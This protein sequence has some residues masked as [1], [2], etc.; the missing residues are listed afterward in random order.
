MAGLPE[1]IDELT[2]G[3][4]LAEHEDHWLQTS[5]FT[6]LENCIQ[7]KAGAIV[8]L[9]GFEEY[10]D[11]DFVNDTGEVL[12]ADDV[13]DFGGLPKLVR[14]A[15]H[16]A[17][18][19]NGYVFAKAAVDAE[20]WSFRGRCSPWV[21]ERTPLI[22]CSRDPLI[23][24][25]TV[26]HDA[27][28]SG[29]WI[30]TA[31]LYWAPGASIT[32]RQLAVSFTHEVTGV[33][34]FQ[35]VQPFAV[36]LEGPLR[37][38][39]WDN[40]GAALVV[41]G[42]KITDELNYVRVDPSGFG[43]E[44]TLIT[45]A[46]YF[47]R[48]NEDDPPDYTNVSYHMVFDVWSDG[49][50]VGWVA[51]R[52]DPD[53]GD[54]DMRRFTMSGTTL[55]QTHAQVVATTGAPNA[56]AIW[57]SASRVTV[58]YAQLVLG[59]YKLVT[60][61]VRAFARALTL[62][63]SVYADTLLFE[64]QSMGLA[65]GGANTSPQYSECVIGVTQAQTS[66]GTDGDFVVW[67]DPN[68]PNGFDGGVQNGFF[69]GES[70]TLYG[71]VTR[72]RWISTTPSLDASMVHLGNQKIVGKPFFDGTRVAWLSQYA[73]GQCPDA[74]SVLVNHHY[75]VV[76]VEPRCG[77]AGVAYRARPLAQ[78]ALES[79]IACP[80]ASSASANDPLLSTIS[81]AFQD[82]RGAWH[83]TGVEADPGTLRLRIVDYRLVAD[84]RVGCF[85]ELGGATY[86]AGA[87]LSQWDGVRCIEAGWMTEPLIEEITFIAGALSAGTRYYALT[88]A[89]TNA[90][91]ELLRSRP[92]VIKS[93]FNAGGNAHRLRCA[94]FSLTN[95]MRG[96]SLT[97]FLEVWR[98]TVAGPSPM[99]LIKRIEVNLNSYA[100]IEVD[101]L[102]SDSAAPFLFR[103][104]L[105][106][107]GA[108]GQEI[109][110]DPPISPQSIAFWKNRIVITD[111]EQV[112]YSKEGLPS[113]QAEFSLLQTIPR[114]SQQRLTAIA[115]LGDMLA[116]FTADSA[117]YIYGEGP[118]ANGEGSSLTG[119]VMLQDPLGCLWPSGIVV[120]P[121]GGLIVPTRGGLQAL[122]KKLEWSYIGAAIERTWET[123]P[124]VRDAEV[125]LGKDR[126]WIALA[127]EVGSDGSF[128]VLDTL[129]NTWSTM[130]PG[131]DPVSVRA[132]GDELFW[133][134][135]T[136]R[137]Y[138]G[139][140]GY[141][142]A[143]SNLYA[144]LVEAPW[145][146]PGGA[147]AEIRLKRLW[148]L[149]ERFAGGGA[150][151]SVT[152]DQEASGGTGSPATPFTF[153]HTFG[154]GT[155][156]IVLVGV[157]VDL[158]TGAVSSVGVT[159]GGVAM[160]A[161]DSDALAATG[162]YV[163][164]I[165]DANVAAGVNTVEVTVNG[166]LTGN[167]HAA[168]VSFFGVKQVIPAVTAS[169]NGSS[170]AATVNLL[171]T[172]DN[173][174]VV[175]FVSGTGGSTTGTVGAGQTERV[176]SNVGG[177]STIY[178]STEPTTSPASTTMSWAFSA[179][180]VWHTVAVEL[181]PHPGSPSSQLRI[182]VGYDFEE[183]Y[184]HALTLTS[185][186]LDL[187]E[188]E[189]LMARIAAP[190]QRCH[191][192]RVKLTET[193]AGSAESQGFRFV[194]LRMLTALRGAKGP[195]KGEPNAGG[196]FTAQ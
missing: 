73:F 188:G 35:H 134:G 23:P 121:G 101:D 85:A 182:D 166:A 128:V 194:A 27:C 146:K 174:W 10:A 117:G 44:G 37:I 11:T 63:S 164:A 70:A 13:A 123:Y 173:S 4:G 114:A 109:A 122:S 144:M 160:T 76:G 133:A 58:A 103:Q 91:G 92:S 119:P 97:V 167:A 139:P 96:D 16:L 135:L 163:F 39:P 116:V 9:P 69:G 45:G 68:G 169:A 80:P 149:F 158:L 172:V 36:G 84:D 59:G 22:D 50:G 66:G 177:G 5:G 142:F 184:S 152:Y 51:T 60:R 108:V 151:E 75:A 42:R 137:T 6:R 94:P 179:S 61:Q 130:L 196:G 161:V 125:E 181:E 156:G 178:A 20:G 56:I 192:F 82:S 34:V 106:Y 71:P 150:P 90:A 12:A 15:G 54:I 30:I 40:A 176:E 183:A 32:A 53:N 154:V 55:T 171:T 118:A 41:F 110:N 190:R 180:Q 64:S 159:Y 187:F 107:E 136:G 17:M 140:R 38:V 175:D 57:K 67:F 88:W 48:A 33:T 8:K 168:A 104:S 31:F 25:A 99:Y 195:L 18:V 170:A 43:T 52:D 1:K 127:N 145:M 105:P 79:A 89:R 19:S 81:G 112:A 115:P 147:L 86:L 21:C 185:P 113:R 129:H 95:V 111:G 100:P 46:G 155:N 29:D 26:H 141:Q 7:D 120:L 126:V 14:R 193:F 148:L 102:I 47:W 74:D 62:G 87:L 132:S 165:L 153:F 138:V 77:S 93:F 124:R 3:A 98:S 191:A 2:F 131:F 83:V 28:R 186:E 65:A 49:A 24:S 162:V 72:G 157:T 78:F 143:G 189:A